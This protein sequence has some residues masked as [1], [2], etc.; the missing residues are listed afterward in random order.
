MFSQTK[1]TGRCHAAAMLAASWNVPRL[2]AAVTE[3]HDR[4]R[5]GLLI[6]S[7]QRCADREAEAAANDTVR[8][9]HTNTEI[10]DMR[11]PPFPLQEPVA[12][13]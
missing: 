11:E 4:D 10:R 3:E 7:R 8:A 5:A 1:I 2:D 9:Q 13:P 12:L 6:T